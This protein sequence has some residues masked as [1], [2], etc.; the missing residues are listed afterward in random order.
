MGGDSGSWEVLYALKGQVK[1][2][3][4]IDA[5]LA[6]VQQ[7]LEKLHQGAKVLLILER[8]QKLLRRKFKGLIH[9]YTAQHSLSEK[10]NLFVFLRNTYTNGD[11]LV[12]E[13][14]KLHQ[15]A[16]RADKIE[17]YSYDQGIDSRW[18]LEK[19]IKDHLGARPILLVFTAYGSTLWKARRQYYV[20]VLV[21]Y[22]NSIQPYEICYDKEHHAHGEIRSLFYMFQVRSGPVWMMLTPDCK[23]GKRKVRITRFEQFRDQYFLKL[24]SK[25][26]RVLNKDDENDVREAFERFVL[27]GITRVNSCQMK[28]G[29]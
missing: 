3:V 19:A 17:R 5:S 20:P 1:N 15:D 14:E 29:E 11:A 23:G 28:I 18:A 16:V 25:K 10:H 4:I 7:E 12:Q 2:L 8:R 26:K 27:W 24:E 21:D 22:E 13:I 6:S 9:E